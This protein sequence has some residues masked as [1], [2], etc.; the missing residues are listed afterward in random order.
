VSKLRNLS[1]SDPLQTPACCSKPPKKSMQALWCHLMPHLLSKKWQTLD[2]TPPHP[3]HKLCSNSVTVTVTGPKRHHSL[4]L[5][6]AHAL[7]SVKSNLTAEAIV[8]LAPLM[9]RCAILASFLPASHVPAS[10]HLRQIRAEL[11][12]QQEC[13]GHSSLAAA[14]QR[15]RGPTCRGLYAAWTSLL[16]TN[17]RSL[18]G[19]NPCTILSLS[20][21]LMP[22]LLDVM[23][24]K[25]MPKA[26]L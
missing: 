17:P 11:P 15:L 10:L 14:C 8:G 6:P 18:F 4:D 2:D 1:R 22:V 23:P 19:S 26:G 12:W 13:G 24:N 25:L 16:G 7:I 5:S 21:G 9:R 20:E 3:Q